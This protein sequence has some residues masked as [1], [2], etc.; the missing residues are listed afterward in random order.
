M[1]LITFT[2]DGQV[3]VGAIDGSGAYAISLTSASKGDP[4]FAS[5]L[6]LIRG[7]EPPCPTRPSWSSC[8][9]WTPPST[10]RR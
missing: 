1:K 7:G 4:R 8:T 10:W 2:A 9:R 6:D 5:M 3:H